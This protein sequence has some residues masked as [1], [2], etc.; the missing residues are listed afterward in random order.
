MRAWR[1][2]SSELQ[3]CLNRAFHHLQQHIAANHLLWIS[4]TGAEHAVQPQLG[5]LRVLQRALFQVKSGGKAEVGVENVLIAIFS[6]QQSR[7][8]LLLT[9]EG[10]GRLDVANHLH[11]SEV[12]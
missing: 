6:E 1:V 2:L 12:P 8:A 3:S 11:L 9:R 4:L 10:I 5:L 7:A